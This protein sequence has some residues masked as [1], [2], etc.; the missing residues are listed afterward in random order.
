LARAL[1]DLERRGRGPR[2]DQRRHR[3]QGESLAQR[4]LSGGAGE[5]WENLVEALRGEGRLGAVFDHAE[6][7]LVEQSGL[8]RRSAALARI[9]K[10]PTAAPPGERRAER[11]LRGGEI[12]RAQKVSPGSGVS[13]K[14]LAVNLDCP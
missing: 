2:A 6:A 5:H 11:R 9:G 7:F 4:V 3:E 14:A 8:E 13:A 12:A 1:V 10:G